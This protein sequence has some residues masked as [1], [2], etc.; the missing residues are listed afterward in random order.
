M[1]SVIYK[2]RVN[3]ASSHGLAIACPESR[4]DDAKKKEKKTA[5]SETAL[6]NDRL[7]GMKKMIA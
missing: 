7:G 3:E 4:S 1:D 5:T 6:W 2:F